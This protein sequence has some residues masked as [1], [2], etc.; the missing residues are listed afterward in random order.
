MIKTK[1]SSIVSHKYDN[2]YICYDSSIQPILQDR[3]L[4]CFTTD[5]FRLNNTSNILDLNNGLIK[6]HF[7][8]KGA[9]SIFNDY[10]LFLGLN[11]SRPIRELMNYIDFT[12]IL[13]N[14]NNNRIKKTLEFCSPIFA[15]VQK[16]GLFYSGDIILSKIEGVT[17]EKYI[18]AN[19]INSK[20][21]DDLA[22]CFK[23]LFDN[24]IFNI[25]MNLKNIIFNE[26]TQ[27]ISFI[28]FDKLIINPSKKGDKK[29]TLE[30]LSKFKKSINKFNLDEKFDWDEFTS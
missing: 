12:C 10:Y 30:V 26:E 16:K 15:Y 13:N 1:Y 19:N 25:D 24:G 27:K 21:Y 18:S 3:I 23:I 11:T 8:R 7:L 6:K 20:F 9:M 28:D 14:L 29:F 2:Q 5:E 22:F 4:S 17:L